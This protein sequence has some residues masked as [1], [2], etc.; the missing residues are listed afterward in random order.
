[1]VVKVDDADLWLKGC[2]HCRYV[3]ARSLKSWLE[4]D[5]SSRR[6]K[7]EPHLA[8]SESGDRAGE[9]SGHAA[10]YPGA[11]WSAALSLATG[12]EEKV[13]HAVWIWRSSWSSDV[14]LGRNARIVLIGAFINV[15][16]NDNDNAVRW[17]SSTM[18]T[19]S[20]RQEDVHAREDGWKLDH[21]F[22]SYPNLRLVTSAQFAY[23]LTLR[24]SE[25]EIHDICMEASVSSAPR[26]R[27][28]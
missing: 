15:N 8:T 24:R 13:V 27:A 4:I 23:G 28:S 17:K 3:P 26:N 1:M 11:S 5:D 12:G 7:A 16:D 18:P 2:R 14:A 21:F 19:N 9:I 20:T 10:E 6:G 25:I 22:W